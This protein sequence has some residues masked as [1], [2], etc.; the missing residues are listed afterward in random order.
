MSSSAHPAGVSQWVVGEIWPSVW[1]MES[2]DRE[3]LRSSCVRGS[4][5]RRLFLS[6][7]FS[8]YVRLGVNLMLTGV[9]WRMTELS[10]VLVPS[11]EQAP[12]L[13]TTT[14][15]SQMII[16]LSNKPLLLLLSKPHIS[17]YGKQI[18][19]VYV[20]IHCKSEIQ[21]MVKI[22]QKKQNIE[23]QNKMQIIQTVMCCKTE[24]KN[25][26]SLYWKVRKDAAVMMLPGSAFQIA[27]TIQSQVIINFHL[28]TSEKFIH[29]SNILT[30]EQ[31]KDHDFNEFTLV[32][33]FT[34]QVL[35]SFSSG[36]N[37]DVLI[38]VEQ[39]NFYRIAGWLEIVNFKWILQ[40]HFLL[41]G[42]FFCSPTNSTKKIKGK[43]RNT[44]KK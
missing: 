30:N 18:I 38:F 29:W 44:L 31:N 23:Q 24:N 34:S 10:S 40:Q 43:S 6:S 27:F 41:A 7:S 13:R 17:Y 33:I 2:Q 19:I 9:W 25:V 16:N 21:I 1:R 12:A 26:F 3:V 14:I 32:I 42:C 5:I 39:T 36:W 22:H 37:Y 35:P 20:Q 4:S 11:S 8:A 28:A 15:Q